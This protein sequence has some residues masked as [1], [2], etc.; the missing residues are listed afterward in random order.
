MG[1]CMSYEREEPQ[2]DKIFSPSEA[3][4]PSANIPKG[5]QTHQH[6]GNDA[7]QKR[8]VES[9][10][11]FMPMTATQNALKAS[12]TAQPTGTASTAA[13]DQSNTEELS[14]I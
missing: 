14:F 1:L 3:K 7:L 4:L 2:S 13:Q 10:M 9:N 5:E 8:E 12:Q 11:V 6:V